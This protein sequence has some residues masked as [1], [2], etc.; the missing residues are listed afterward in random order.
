VKGAK[1]S[2]RESLGVD[3]GGDGQGKGE[4]RR[5]IYSSKAAAGQCVR[6]P[7]L[8]GRQTQRGLPDD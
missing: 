8:G 1:P 7:R 2:G 3:R 4:G 6:V 5:L